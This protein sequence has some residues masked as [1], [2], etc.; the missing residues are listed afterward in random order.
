MPGILFII[1]SMIIV[2]AGGILYWRWS[3][4]ER[5]LLGEKKNINIIER[6]DENHE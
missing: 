4:R 3:R 5:V 2:V 1:A 6:S